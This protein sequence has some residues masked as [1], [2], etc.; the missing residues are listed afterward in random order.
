MKDGPLSLAESARALLAT[1]LAH[2][3]VQADTSG[4][5]RMVK[6]AH[7]NESRDDVAV[8]LT[9]SC[10][11]FVRYPPVAMVEPTGPVVVG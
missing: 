6:A 11:A 1:S 10:G 4:N 5:L 2:S 9:L 3:K 7:K 8:A